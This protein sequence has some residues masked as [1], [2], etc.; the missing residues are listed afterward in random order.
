M[1]TIDVAIFTL[2]DISHICIAE[3]FFNKLELLGIHPDVISL[4]E[5]IRE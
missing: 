5:P 1:S 2:K 3:S 4:T